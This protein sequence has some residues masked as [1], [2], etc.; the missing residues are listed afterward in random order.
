MGAYEQVSESV[1]QE[2]ESR[3]RVR[4][5]ESQ[6]VGGHGRNEWFLTPFSVPPLVRVVTSPAKSAPFRSLGK[7]LL[8]NL[9]N[10]FLNQIGRDFSERIISPRRSE[11]RRVGKECRSRWS[12]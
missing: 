9:E 7:H 1:E 2:M 8:E 4:A 3:K 5:M 12:P 10:F 6:C 11:E